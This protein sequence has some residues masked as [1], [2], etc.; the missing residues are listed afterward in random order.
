MNPTQQARADK[1]ASMRLKAK[2]AF[3]IPLPDALIV[4]VNYSD[5]FPCMISKDWTVNRAK[6]ILLQQCGLKSTDSDSLILYSEDKDE[7][8]TKL[9]LDDKVSNCILDMQDL[10]LIHV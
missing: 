8:L 7:N 1:V 10:H 6:T 9:K 4:F 5:R 3:N 2:N